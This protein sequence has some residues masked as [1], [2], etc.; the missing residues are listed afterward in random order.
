MRL[1]KKIYC[2]YFLYAIIV[3]CA[4]TSLY[5]QEKQVAPVKHGRQEKNVQ[6]YKK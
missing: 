2:I 1:F 6:G 4:G 3:C 5:A